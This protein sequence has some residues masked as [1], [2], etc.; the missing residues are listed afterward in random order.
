MKFGVQISTAGGVWHAYERAAV[1]GCDAAMI[2]T[3]SNRQWNA[4]PFSAEDISR[5][6]AE[7][8]AYRG[9]VEPIIIHA[10]YLINVASPDPELWQK[11]Y[12]ALRDEI[13]RAESLQLDQLV[14]HPGSHMGEGEEA[15]LE[16]IALALQTAIADTPNYRVRIC[17]ET[18][19]GQGS[20][21]GNRF[22][23]LAYLLNAVNRPE[24]MGV[25]FDTCHV[26]VAGY[27]LRS[28]EAYQQT[29]AQFDE[30]I[31]LDQ[32][33]CFHFNDSKHELGSRKDRHEHIGRGYLGAE[34]FAQFI[35]DPRWENHVACLETAE[36]E[37]GE[38]GQEI[39]MDLV[40]LA[41][42]RG[43]RIK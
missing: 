22:E 11:S 1:L 30:I 18:M 36:T 31:G 17:L 23:H 3:K 34:A 9:R 15:G 4:K 41:T 6:R 33:Y 10:A 13:E 16:R 32:L 28:A 35:N 14:F 43:L 27:D 5:F 20:N 39:N 37:K 42:L 19:A 2:Y 29:M 24:R 21:L 26:F 12:N 25:C 38:D 40:N 7:T 8:E